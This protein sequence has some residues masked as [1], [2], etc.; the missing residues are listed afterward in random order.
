MGRT[1][2]N[3]RRDGIG[4]VPAVHGHEHNNS[5][6]SK[7]ATV[8]AIDSLTYEQDESDAWRAHVALDHYQHRGRFWN[9]GKH[10]TMIRYLTIAMVGITQAGVAYFTNIL[11]NYFVEVCSLMYRLLRVLSFCVYE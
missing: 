2:K 6:N 3:I 4:A 9:Q 5:N 7:H 1:P 11:S 10:Q 8:V